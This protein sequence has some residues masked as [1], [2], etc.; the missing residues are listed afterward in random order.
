MAMTTGPLIIAAVAILILLVLAV[1]AFVIWYISTSNKL[2]TLVI[3]IEEAR[4]GIDIAL[5]KRY[6]ILTKMFEI[7]KG[8]AAFEKQ[9]IIETIK[10]RTGKTISECSEV[11]KSLDEAARQINVA[12]EA[13]PQLKADQSFKQL[14]VTVADVEE[15]L[16]AS[17]R[18]YNSNVSVFNQMTV[19]FPSSFVANKLGFAPVDFF[20]AEETKRDDVSMK[21]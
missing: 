17:R 11:N 14:Q 12:V 8:Y 9:T 20:Q 19:R 15:H 16:S 13:Y 1:I 2:K 6:D 21:F 10:M 3:K 18:A 5:T 7:T 4:S